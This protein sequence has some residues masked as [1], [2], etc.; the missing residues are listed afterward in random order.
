MA[1]TPPLGPKVKV[2]FRPISS[3]TF[4]I[5]LG[6]KE[7]ELRLY[8]STDTTGTSWTP[9]TCRDWKEA[10]KDIEQI[11]TELQTAGKFNPE[12]VRK[13]DLILEGELD[14][15]AQSSPIAIKDLK[16]H[17]LTVVKEGSTV[18]EEL[19]LED[20]VKEKINT[21]IT[22][23][24]E[25]LRTAKP[26]TSSRA[27]STQSIPQTAT[28]AQAFYTDMQKSWHYNVGGGGNCAA[29]A[30]ADAIFQQTEIYHRD[31]PSWHAELEGSQ[32]DLRQKITNYMLEHPDEF[33]ED[34]PIGEISGALKE[35]KRTDKTVLQ[36]TL[37]T[38]GFQALETLLTKSSLETEE[39]EP[40]DKKQL[41]SLYAKYIREGGTYLDG[42]FW[43]AAATYLTQQIVVFETKSDTSYP[44]IK[45]VYNPVGIPQRKI[46]DTAL[47]VHFSSGHYHS[48]T[49][50][51]TQISPLVTAHNK[52][53]D[54]VLQTFLETIDS[55]QQSTPPTDIQQKLRTAYI[56]LQDYNPHAY[57]VVKWLV[58]N[59]RPEP[60]KDTSDSNYGHTKIS[61]SSYAN[62]VT[63]LSQ[64]TPHGIHQKIALTNFDESSGG[65]IAKP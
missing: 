22:L 11:F 54:I 51:A 41:V 9:L 44:N 64:F 4:I 50:S 5:K 42:P 19:V 12:V 6:N 43:L 63:L 37:Q 40:E 25:H 31:K 32:K 24:G 36:T 49:R 2:E 39:L 18:E 65:L 13:A 61:E 26:V 16:A 1:T 52:Q 30:L 59:K 35:A 17:K 47:Y 55:V 45:S 38:E 27:Q 62:I 23:L 53:P 58:W 29:Y 21:T 14:T 3:D 8:Q 33:I 48:V 20:P 7:Y 28:T 15:S 10:A 57:T 34:S 56:D 46:E 60:D